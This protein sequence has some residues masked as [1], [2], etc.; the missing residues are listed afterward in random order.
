MLTTEI[1]LQPNNTVVEGTFLICDLKLRPFNEKANHFLTF[2]LQDKAGTVW[3]KIWD[4][5]EA[6]SKQLSDQKITVA[7]IIGRT[8]LF[9]NKIQVIVDK[10][11]KAE[12]YNIKDLVKVSTNNI[13]VMWDELVTIVDE[14][15]KSDSL[16]Q[17]WNA[18]KSNQEF[19][20]KFKLWPGGKGNVHHAY[21]HGLL[22]HTLSVM[23]IT[24]QFYSQLD[25]I[26]SI[27][28]TIIG[29]FLHDI[30]KIEAY[31]YDN[32]TTSLS[33]LGRMHDH[34]V[35]S[36]FQFR[37]ITEMLKLKDS[38]QIV[39][40]IGHIILSHHGFKEGLV[41]VKPMTIEAKFVAM[42]DYFDSDTNHMLKQLETNVDT[43]GWVF[44]SL[45][46]QFYFK[47]QLTKRKILGKD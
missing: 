12:S 46:N 2:T 5:A 47:R 35:L 20:E 3:A 15:L 11:K 32:M 34:S 18:F 26:L 31:N 17:I 37:S 7:T 42:A 10:I 23:K 43:Q 40:E 27:E 29:A 24:Y 4:N 30:G 8:N 25:I 6:I 13:D 38:Q 14:S 39:E 41:I 21:K 22:E 16:K 36:Y 1:L 33:N 19:L 28:K 9:N 44:D 45:N